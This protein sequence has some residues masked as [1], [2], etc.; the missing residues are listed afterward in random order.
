[1]CVEFRLVPLH[2]GQIR[3]ARINAVFNSDFKVF[4]SFTILLSVSMLLIFIPFYLF[5]IGKHGRKGANLRGRKPPY[6]AR[7]CLS[8]RK[9]LFEYP[10]LAER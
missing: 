1:M 3:L 10:L 2:S 5:L 4:K 9:T 6:R 8:F 7:Y